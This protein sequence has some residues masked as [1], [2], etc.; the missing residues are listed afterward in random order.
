MRN[1]MVK[2]FMVWS[3]GAGYRCRPMRRYDRMRGTKFPEKLW[4]RIALT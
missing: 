1:R 4:H 2:V 3:R